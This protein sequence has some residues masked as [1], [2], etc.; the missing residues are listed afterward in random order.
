MGRDKLLNKISEKYYWQ[1][2]CQGIREFIQGCPD[3]HQKTETQLVKRYSLETN[4]DPE[5]QTLIHV[6]TKVEEH[7]GMD[8]EPDISGVSL[9]DSW[10]TSTQQA[11]DPRHFWDIVSN[12]VHVCIFLEMSRV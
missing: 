1:G 4:T 2:I 3:C 5:E 10:I 7:D 6:A 12:L 11:L 8:V 9:S